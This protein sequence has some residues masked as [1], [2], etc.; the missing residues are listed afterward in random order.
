MLLRSVVLVRT[1]QSTAEW[2]CMQ[3]LEIFCSPNCSEGPL[4]CIWFS[5]KST[6]T[7][8]VVRLNSS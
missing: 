5:S 6:A 2:S 4:R 1:E 7:S 3:T 8:D